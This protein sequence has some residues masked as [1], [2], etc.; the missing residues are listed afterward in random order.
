VLDSE[1]FSGTAHAGHNFVRDE[2][3]SVLTADFRDARGVTFWRHRG[4]ES[5]SD[6]RLEDEGRGFLR[7]VFE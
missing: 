7:F 2:E 3:N 1:R 6:D 4:A 5:G